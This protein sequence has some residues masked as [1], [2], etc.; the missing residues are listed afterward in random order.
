MKVVFAGTPEFAAWALEAI[1]AAGFEVSLVLTQPDRPAGRGQK[2]QASAVKQTALAHGL[3]VYQPERLKDAA[4]HAP[5]RAAAGDV[6]V[7]AAYGLILPQAVLDIPARGCINIHASLLP[8]WRG[9]APIQRAI[10]AGD[11]ET[12]VAIMQ[13]EAGLDTGP[14][15]LT[16][17]LPIDAADTAASLHDKLAAQGARLIVEALRRLPTLTPVPQPEAGVTYAHKI[18]K[19]EGRLDWT[20][21]AVE[22]G[23][24]IRAFNPFP[25]AVAQYGDTPIKIWNAVPAAGAAAPGTILQADAASLIVACGE[26]ALALTELQKP[27]GKRLTAAD[28]L[29]SFPLRAGDR[30]A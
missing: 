6:M 30:F 10:E 12:G 3:P 20:R 24:R 5:I 1:I 16:E 19:A 26:G 4:S 25:G 21:S 27:G 17:S 23:R 15:L 11:A 8:R 22:L 13:M 2:L 9:A 29:R 14:V 18:E 7:V 28:F